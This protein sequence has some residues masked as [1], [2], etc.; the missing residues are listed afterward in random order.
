MLI[1]VKWLVLIIVASIGVGMFVEMIRRRAFYIR[2]RIF[3]HTE[4]LHKQRLSG[5]LHPYTLGPEALSH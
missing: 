5:R 1:Y 2:Y 3:H 4:R